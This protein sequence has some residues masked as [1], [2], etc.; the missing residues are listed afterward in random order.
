MYVRAK[1]VFDWRDSWRG[2]RQV[3]G[4]WPS[5]SPDKQSRE[6][7]QVNQKQQLFQTVS[8]LSLNTSNLTLEAF[9][10]QWIRKN[11]QK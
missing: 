2:K 6:L 4:S 9:N 1:L 5:Y 3:A 11:K 10:L 8:S 7:K